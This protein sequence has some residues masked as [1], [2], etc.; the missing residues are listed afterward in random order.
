MV[1]GGCNTEFDAGLPLGKEN[2]MEYLTGPERAAIIALSDLAKQ[3]MPG[4]KQ[5]EADVK[6]AMGI[7]AK[8]DAAKKSRTNGI[9]SPPKDR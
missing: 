2:V 1:F 3:L 6:A 8:S 5:V 4:S 7:V 9:P